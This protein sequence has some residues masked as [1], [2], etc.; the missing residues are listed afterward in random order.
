MNPEDH[1]AEGDPERRD[2]YDVAGWLFAD[3]L[4]ALTLLFSAMGGFG[5]SVIPGQAAGATAG[6]SIGPP[7]TPMPDLYA[8]TICIALSKVA[9]VDGV[10]GEAEQK[11][12]RGIIRESLNSVLDNRAVK[13]LTFGGAGKDN[14]IAAERLA[15]QVNALLQQMHRDGETRTLFGGDH[16][17]SYIDLHDENKDVVAIEMF[18]L[19]RPPTDF[20]ESGY[21]P[22]A[23]PYPAAP[24]LR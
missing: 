7:P 20:R 9:H 1:E 23:D 4:I 2:M 14:G 3:L 15:Q 8:Q 24:P 18:L 12:L 11:R 16:F 21:C 10:I 17:R 5:G 6:P 22:R 19:Q 13:V